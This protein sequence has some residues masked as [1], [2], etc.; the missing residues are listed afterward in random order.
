MRI[1]ETEADIAEAAA[2]LGAQDPRLADAVAL[3]GLPPLRRRPPGF[4]GL[5]RLVVGQQ[6]STASAAAIWKRMEE[7]GLVTPVT[8]LAAGEEGLRGAGLSRPK[9]AY[10]LAIAGSVESGGFSFER[11]AGLPDA[12]ALAEMTKLKG[13]GRWTA[14]A[15][16]LMC[17]GRP[18][19]FPVGDLALQE[20]ARRLYELD[21]RPREA[22][23][24]EMT[25]AWRPWRA[26]AAR[27]IWAYYAA[28][29]KSGG[30]MP[31]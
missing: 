3:A 20:G 2:A 28:T 8:V 24:A 26:V 12:A 9:A 10:A 6:V 15:Y 21:E 4:A 19:V 23:L 30:G 13:V 1:I 18:D 17:E 22:H 25:E 29:G 14:E 7:A 27:V 16:Q 5:L 31:A 11:H